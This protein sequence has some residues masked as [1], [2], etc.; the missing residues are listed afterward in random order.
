MTVWLTAVWLLLAA[1]LGSAPG[2]AMAL[3]QKHGPVAVHC[4]DAAD[5]VVAA[6]MHDH[7]GHDHGNPERAQTPCQQGCAACCPAGWV[8]ALPARLAPPRIAA[9]APWPR[10][11]R[12]PRLRA[13]AADIFKPPRAGS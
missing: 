10:P 13:P 9:A 11:D 5:A 3:P 6:A 2:M 12:A 4:H 7:G 1:V 8:A